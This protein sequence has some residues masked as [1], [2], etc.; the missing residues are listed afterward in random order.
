M[1]D[2]EAKQTPTAV[3]AAIEPY[4]R[5]AASV[6]SFY[7]TMAW[8]PRQ[9]A[10]E[11]LLE[12]TAA[13]ITRAVKHMLWLVGFWSAMMSLTGSF[14][15]LI[16]GPKVEFLGTFVLGV[17]VAVQIVPMAC[18]LKRLTRRYTASFSQTLL[19]F[20]DTFNLHLG[21]SFLIYGIF[22]VFGVP[23]LLFLYYFRFPRQASS[24]NDEAFFTWICDSSPHGKWYLVF[25]GVFIAILCA[26]AWIRIFLFSA[27]GLI[28]GT[29]NGAWWQGLWRLFASILLMG[30]ALMVLIGLIV[31]AILFLQRI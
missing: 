1:S 4:R 10:D 5:M 29:I 2:S 21:T 14:I 16:G 7:W 19:I 15:E 8:H 28:A 31:G 18:I 13:S 12:P 20:L 30:L 17:F 27:P 25:V 22:A 23:V 11:H 6:L 26:I 9:F 3:Q 24:T